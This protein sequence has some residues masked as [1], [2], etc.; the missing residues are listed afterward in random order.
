[1]GSPREGIGS[2]AAPKDLDLMTIKATLNQVHTNNDDGEGG[3]MAA[4]MEFMEK[5]PEYKVQVMENI[6]GDQGDK[7]RVAP[8][9]IETVN[10]LDQMLEDDTEKPIQPLKRFTEEEMTGMLDRLQK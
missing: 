3:G 10:I 5:N 7:I 6:I 8:M 1:M 4:V 9:E 2:L